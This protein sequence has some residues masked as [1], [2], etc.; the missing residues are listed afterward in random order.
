MFA[1]EPITPLDEELGYPCYVVSSN[2]DESGRYVR[3]Y[4]NFAVTLGQR[5]P[6]GKPLG[7]RLN[8]DSHSDIFVGDCRPRREVQGSEGATDPCDTS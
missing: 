6:L 4:V 3:R 2:A 1:A 8:P 5:F 7:R